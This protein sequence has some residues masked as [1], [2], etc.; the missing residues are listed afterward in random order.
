MLADALEPYNTGRQYLN[1]TE[2]PTH[3]AR[4]YPPP[5]YRRLQAV[6]A[7]FDPKNVVRANHPIAP[8]S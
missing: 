5:V 1:F 8:A 3:S 4:F 7:A 2:R 6:K